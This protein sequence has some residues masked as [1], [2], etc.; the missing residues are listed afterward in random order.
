MSNLQDFSGS[1]ADLT[2]KVKSEGH[3]VLADFYATWCPG[4]RR[5]G[6]LLPGIASEFPGVTILKCDIEQNEELKDHYGITSIPVVKFLKVQDGNL[7]EL[8]SVQGP[9][10]TE[11]RAKIGKYQ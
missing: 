1:L 7:S 4:C 6:Q 2:N 10:M 11:I 3:L 5:L 8:D 9:N